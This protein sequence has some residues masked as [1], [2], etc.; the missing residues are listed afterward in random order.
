MILRFTSSCI[1]V[2]KHVL[3]IKICQ[4]FGWAVK[5]EKVSLYSQGVVRLLG[6]TCVCREEPGGISIGRERYV[7]AQ[8]SLVLLSHPIPELLH[9]PILLYNIVSHTVEDQ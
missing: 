6:D 1:Y 4:T 5:D 3:R 7:H 9:C 2:S 8:P